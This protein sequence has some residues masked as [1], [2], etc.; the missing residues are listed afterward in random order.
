[1]CPEAARAPDR[2]VVGQVGSHPVPSAGFS[3]LMEGKNVSSE[4]R[5]RE[6]RSRGEECRDQAGWTQGQWGM[7][8]STVEL[9]G[10]RCVQ[11]CQP[12]PPVL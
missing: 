2:A 7:G 1:M 10:S 12:L 4:E 3:F 11:A 6:W 5:G 9:A 8:M